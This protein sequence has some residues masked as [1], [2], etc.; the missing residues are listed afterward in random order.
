MP[1]PMRFRSFRLCAGFR[2]V[3]LSSSAIVDLHEVPDLPKHACEDRTVVVLRGLPDP[4][5]PQRAEC[6]A[7]LLALADLA[8][9]LGYPDF[10]HS[11]PPAAREPCR[12]RPARSSGLGPA[13]PRRG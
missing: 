4:A 1:R 3:R 10:R 2:E 13:R 5:E 11:S 8:T 12:A 7:M 6:A 9:N